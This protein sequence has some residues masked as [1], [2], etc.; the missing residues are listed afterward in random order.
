M[1]PTHC[2]PGKT[3]HILD[4]VITNEQTMINE[5]YYL[6]GLGCSYHV[7]LSFKFMCYSLHASSDNR[8]NMICIMQILKKCV[9]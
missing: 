5:V 1:E 2:R 8:P 9:S 7:C 3:P 4:L 6:P